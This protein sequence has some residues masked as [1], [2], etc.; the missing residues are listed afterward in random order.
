MPLANEQWLF[1]GSHCRNIARIVA[2]GFDLK[3]ARVS[4]QFG[5]G[6]YFALHSSTSHGYVATEALK[7]NIPWP[8]PDQ[9]SSDLLRLAK[10][11]RHH[12]LLLCTV[13]LGQEGSGAAGLTQ[14]P[15]GNHSVGNSSMKVVYNSAQ[16][17]PRYIIAYQ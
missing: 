9:C 15:S 10:Q 2:E 3:L 14:A 6:V 12:V 4:G 13:L 8:T 1:H 5:A 16:A 11:N 7:L 17:Y